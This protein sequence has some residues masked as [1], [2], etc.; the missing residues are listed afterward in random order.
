MV[1]GSTVAGRTVGPMDDPFDLDR[2]VAA[3]DADRTWDTA[4]AELRAGR[5][6]THWMWFVLPQI[7]GLGSSR[8]AV[9]YAIASVTEAR[10]YLGHPVLGARL[11]E[12]ARVVLDGPTD[13]A[14]A[15]LGSIDAVKL[16]S[17]MTLFARA[18]PDEPVFP[19]VLDRFFGGREDEATLARL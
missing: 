14:T 3:Q 17:S 18:A 11:R 2:F 1:T 13:D 9:H 8:T 5:K 12:A 15:L 7:A 19:A 4:L 16:R 10:A 6:R